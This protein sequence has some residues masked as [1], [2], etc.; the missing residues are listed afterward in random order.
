[1]NVC[2]VGY[3]AIGP[4]HAKALSKL[5]NVNIYGI[6]DINKMRADKGAEEYNAKA[7]YTYEE[8]IKDNNIDSVHICTPHYL[9]YDM[10]V[11]ALDEGK[12]VV[13]EKPLVMTK[14]EL[15]SLIKH[16]GSDKICVVMQNRLNP[17][18]QKLKCIIDSGE[19]GKIKAVKGFL[20]WH[21]TKEYYESEE[22]RGKWAT[23]GGGVLINQAVHTLDFFSFLVGNIDSVKANMFNYSLEGEIE[24]EDTVTTYLSYKNGVKGIF[25]ATNA[26]GE[27]S[28]PQFEISFEKGNVRYID[29]KLYIGD[30]CIEQDIKPEVG[31]T[32]WGRSHEILMERFYSENKY[33]NINDVKHTMDIMF[34]IYESA[35]IGKE[36]KL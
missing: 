26:Y 28:A 34:A 32:Y 5:R 31:K 23:E 24:V 17:C 22:W 36:I 19:L 15:D 1:M 14:K 13:C 29:A 12:R 33:F 21:R 20:T 6:C 9:H 27:N 10:I 30:A 4:V 11:K 3:G 35:K 18:I 25:M 7:I 8:C 16:K 2:I